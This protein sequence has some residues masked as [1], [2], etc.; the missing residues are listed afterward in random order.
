MDEPES[1]EKPRFFSTVRFQSDPR[2]ATPL[3]VRKPSSIPAWRALAE[4]KPLET[5]VFSIRQRRLREDPVPG[6]GGP[7]EGDFFVIDAPDW[8]N[9]VALTDE[10]ELASGRRRAWPHSWACSSAHSQAHEPQ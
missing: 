1:S 10:D 6:E 7:K 4:K 5:R 2:L 8:V 3:P 9:V